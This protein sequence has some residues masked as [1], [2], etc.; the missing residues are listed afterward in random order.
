MIQKVSYLANCLYQSPWFSATFLVLLGK[1]WS[2]ASW[3]TAG[4]GTRSTRACWNKMEHLI[5]CKKYCLSPVE[6]GDFQFL[7][8]IF[9]TFG[10]ISPMT[11]RFILVCL[12]TFISVRK[13]LHLNPILCE[14]PNFSLYTNNMIFYFGIFY[15]FLID[16]SWMTIRRAMIYFV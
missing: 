14:Q 16:V 8:R 5:V 2:P 12:K 3:I 6:R 9:V 4:T 13:T 10:S 1:S 11:I 7:F 15:V